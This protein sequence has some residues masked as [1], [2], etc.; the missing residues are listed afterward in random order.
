MITNMRCYSLSFLLLV[1]KKDRSDD[2]LLRSC[3]S[4]ML[5]YLSNNG[6]LIVRDETGFCWEVI[7]ST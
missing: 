2:E 3:S 7:W 6:S 5:Y 4:L 1:S